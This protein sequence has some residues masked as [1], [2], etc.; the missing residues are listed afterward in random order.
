[1][2]KTLK[3][4]RTIPIHKVRSNPENPRVIK[5][6]EYQKLRQSILDD[7]YMESQRE[8]I[9]DDSLMVLGGN[10]RLMVFKDLGYKDVLVSVFS[11]KIYE[12]Y[13]SRF[14]K[15]KVP[16]YEKACRNLVILDNK[17]F[18]EYDFE[19]MANLWS[20]EA[21]DYDISF[22]HDDEA[23]SPDLSPETNYGEVT[24]AEIQE[25]A[26]KLAEQ[27]IK[28]RKDQDIICP[29]CGNEFSYQI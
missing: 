13:K 17:S 14:P 4:L 15:S 6:H 11:L 26:K 3:D 10:M 27:M 20:E 28:E 18:G 12:E 16:S 5:D 21:Q 22:V 9:V 23:F 19:V 1:M 2:P 25:Q 7:P 8:I 29:K 24:Q